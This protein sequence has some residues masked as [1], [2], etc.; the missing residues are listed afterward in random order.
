MAP[1]AEASYILSE[2]GGPGSGL[3]ESSSPRKEK[4]ARRRLPAAALGE[5]PR[6][7]RVFPPSSPLS[8]LVP[9]PKAGSS[10]PSQPR[11]WRGGEPGG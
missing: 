10:V 1:G 6:S 8:E 3:G 11:P 7:V 9:S 4:A 5:P 2:W